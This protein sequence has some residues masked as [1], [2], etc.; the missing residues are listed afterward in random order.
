MSSYESDMIT[1]VE[2]SFEARSQGVEISFLAVLGLVKLFSLHHRNRFLCTRRRF[3]PHHSDFA[4][5]YQ[6]DFAFLFLVKY[7][8]LGL[9]TPG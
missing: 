1:A 4:L 8:Q 7:P 3:V 9:F 5:L 2:S 6:I